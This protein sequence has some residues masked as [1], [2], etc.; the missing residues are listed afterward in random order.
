M[1]R[2]DSSIWSLLE[3]EKPSGQ[4][5]W[6]RRA[7]P[8]VNER[9]IGALD[10]EGGRHFL[11]LLRENEAGIQDAQTRGV[12]VRTQD[13]IIPGHEAG[14]YLDIAC[15]DVGGYD[16]FDL[17]GGEIADRLSAQKEP[18]GE[19]IS[20]VLAKWRRFWGQ[21]PRQILSREEQVG[22]FSEIWFLFVWLI[23][24]V[25]AERAVTGWCGPAGTRHDFMWER[26]S[27]EVKGTT[28]TR[29]RIH[30]IHGLDQLLVPEHG[31]LLFFS[32]RLRQESGANNT[33]PSVISACRRA[34]ENNPDSASLFEHTLAQSGYSGIYESDYLQIKYR[35]VEEAL[36]RVIG[37]FPKIINESFKESVP[38]GV[39][40]VDYEINLSGHER[41]IIAKSSSEMPEILQGSGGIKND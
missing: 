27:I 11:I 8:K 20:R 28:S 22:L 2:I 30:R 33:L 3:A 6:A 9:L 1:S 31:S 32:L 16:A 37:E 34:L 40:K 14:R 7:S 25:G 26:L 15:N 12:S 13:L 23:P 35:I 17:I 24:R 10:S 5:L 4:T 39:E 29:G 21:L 18:V 36:F 19:S 38:A 41:L